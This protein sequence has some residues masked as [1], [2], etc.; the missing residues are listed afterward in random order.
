MKYFTHTSTQVL[1]L[2][3][4]IFVA[5]II[6]FPEL[7]LYVSGLF[8]NNHFYMKGSLWES[9]LYQSVPAL[10]IIT[11]V[12]V[13]LLCCYN[14]LTGKNIGCIDIRKTVYLLLVLII[15]SG[16][17]VNLGLKEHSGRARPVHI[18]EFNGS[19]QF[20]PAFI[21]SDQCDRNCSFSS[22]HSS[23]AFFFIAVAM[24]FKKRRTALLIAFTY[25]SLVSLARIAA[26]GHF[27]S[28]CIMSFFIMAFTADFLFRV[29]QPVTHEP[30]NKITPRLQ[31]ESGQ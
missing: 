23:A 19:K 3:F 30:Q 11:I 8:Y 21:I 5:T 24:L 15:G 17:I 22:G 29:L 26:G 31:R 13:L 6:A 27:L 18:S 7:D 28:D 16:I 14:L 2:A 4:S 20:T 12:S 9:I 25:G 1:F 10:L